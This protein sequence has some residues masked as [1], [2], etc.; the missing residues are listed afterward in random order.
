M[1]NQEISAMSR[2]IQSMI[3]ATSVVALLFSFTNL[4]AA[5]DEAARAAYESSAT[6]PTTVQGI[7]SFPAPPANFNP[8]T[9]SE[10]T[11]ATYGLPPHPDRAVDPDGYAKWAK[12][13]T[14]PTKRWDGE[15]KATQIYHQPMKPAKTSAAAAAAA[16]ATVS[17]AAS[18]GNSYNWSGAVNTNTLT[19]YNPKTSYYYIVSEFNVPVAKQASCDGGWDYGSAWNGIDGFNSGD[20]LQGGVEFDAYCSGGTTSSFYSAWIEWYPFSETRVFGVNAG[21]DIFVETWDTSSTQGY[22]YLAD[23]TTATSAVYSLAPPSGTSLI[24]NS[25]EYVV[26]RPGVNGGLATLT[27]YISDFWALD[28]DYNFKLTQNFPGSTA[29]A[30]WLLNMLDNNGNVISV[31]TVEGKYGIFFQYE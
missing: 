13:M 18:L 15:L 7:R 10:L 5:Q 29:P 26:E 8:L 28:A 6:M 19:K 23:L 2:S 14:H 17:N 3:H 30:T 25:A 16:T 9:A 4:L 21:D 1:K 27:N 12:A 31:P 24:G 11:L 20:V 22:V